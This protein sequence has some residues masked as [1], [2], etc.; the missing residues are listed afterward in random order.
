MKL[1]EHVLCAIDDADSKKFDAALL[2]ACIAID[3]TSRRLYPAEARVGRRYIDCLRSYYWLL[4]PMMGAGINLVETRFSNIKL[5]NTASPDFAEIVYEIFRCSQ[6]HGDEVPSQFSV[7]RS[8]GGFY[9]EWLLADGEVHMPDRVVW[10]LLAVAVFSK[11][12]G[13]ERTTGDY[14]LSLGDE[15]FPIRDWWG[16]E[17]DFRATA[18]KYNKVRVKL[19]NLEGFGKKK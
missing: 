8:E 14:Y 11:V 13:G 10:A 5:R 16:R 2:H 1:S 3:A 6:A 19:E 17:D 18:D 9:S 7:T 12:N 4:E 15:R